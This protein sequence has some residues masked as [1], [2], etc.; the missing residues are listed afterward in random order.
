MLHNICISKTASMESAMSQLNQTARNILFVLERDKLVG[1]L[2]DGDVRRCL[3]AGGSL[4]DAVSKAA[5]F[6]PTTACSRK[7]AQELFQQG[8]LYPAI[9][10]VN[11]NGSL[12]DIVFQKESNATVSFPA[13]NIPVVI[14]AGGKGTRLE[15]YTKILPKPLIPVGDLPIIEHIMGRFTPYDCHAFHIIVNYKKQLMKAYFSESEHNYDIHWYDEDKPLGTGGGL[16]LL[17]GKMTQTFFLTNCDILLLADYADMLR[18]H[19]EHGNA[20]TMVC[21]RKNV[22]IPYGVIETGETGDILSMREKPEFSFLTNTGMYIVEPEVL[23]DIQEDVP[24][25]FPTI[26]EQQKAKGRKIAVY[27]VEEDAW[28]DMGQMEELR[29]MEERL[30]QP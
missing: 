4:D 27:P 6:H 28:M 20:V 26:M 19:R 21:A 30:K 14:M 17:K 1:T 3:L 12:V 8:A 15:P 13:L 25:G 29:K 23:E 22:T 10:V 5:N 9:P 11:Q 16:S 2:T 7:Q 18:F 24:I